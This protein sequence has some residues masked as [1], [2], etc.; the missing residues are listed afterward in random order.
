M[1]LHAIT[2]AFEKDGLRMMQETIK[3]GRGQG[4]VVVENLRP[5]FVDAVGGDNG[6]TVLIAMAEDLKQ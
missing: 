3:Q 2:F 6:G 5:F 4:A 1:L